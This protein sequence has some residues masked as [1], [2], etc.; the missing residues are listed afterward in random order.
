ML[1]PAAGRCHRRHQGLLQGMVKLAASVSSTPNV[2]CLTLQARSELMVPQS[3]IW[4]GRPLGRGQSEPGWNSCTKVSSCSPPPQEV[5]RGCTASVGLHWRVSDSVEE[6][7]SQSHGELYKS[8]RTGGLLLLRALSRP[9][10][11]LGF[12]LVSV[13]HV[14]TF[15][16]S[17]SPSLNIL[18]LVAR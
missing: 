12:L 18:Q 10:E 4:Y 1:P 7:L 6:I 5:A 14:R 8:I 2:Y 3:P 17:V 9:E 11:G 16:F 13:V 15:Q